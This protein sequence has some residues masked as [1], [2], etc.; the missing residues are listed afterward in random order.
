LI[1]I[2]CCNSKPGIVTLLDGVEVKQVTQGDTRGTVYVPERDAIYFLSKA[3]LNIWHMGQRAPEQLY[4]GARDWHGLIHN[5][6][7]L[8]AVD[9]VNDIIFEFDLD[10][11]PVASYEWKPEREGRLHT[12]DMWIDGTDVYTCCFNWGICKNGEKLDLG[13]NSQPHSVIVHEGCVYFCASNKGEVHDQQGD[14]FC[15]PGGFTRGLLATPEGLWV[16]SSQQRHGCGGT[17]ALLQL[18]G[19]LSGDLIKTV[20]L[21]TNEVYSITTT[22]IGAGH[23]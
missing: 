22:E 11:K 4:T 8:L 9:P 13:L 3:A 23:V 2:G 16:G 18:Y 19:W 20:P 10:G 12:N 5:D 21:P 14:V 17:G 7:S 1:V 6:G 15:A